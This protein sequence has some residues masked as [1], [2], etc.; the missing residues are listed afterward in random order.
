MPNGSM[1]TSG[2]VGFTFMLISTKFLLIIAP[3]LADMA[4][5]IILIRSKY[6]QIN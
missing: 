3:F 2:Q 4:I 5:K 1:V 6:L